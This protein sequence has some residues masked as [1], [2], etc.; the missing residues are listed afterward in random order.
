VPRCVGTESREFRG[1][2]REVDLVFLAKGDDDQRNRVAG[3]T[4]TL[5]DGAT[6]VGNGRAGSDAAWAIK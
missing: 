3:D 4:V 5:F 6:V 1:K 2:R